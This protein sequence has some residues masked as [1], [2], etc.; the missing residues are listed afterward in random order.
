M[1]KRRE[2]DTGEKIKPAKETCQKRMSQDP[3]NKED[4]Q[5]GGNMLLG[6]PLT[7][8]GVAGP[9]FVIGG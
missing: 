1:E 3:Q 4:I 2:I 8:W 9:H 6:E 7:E 5:E